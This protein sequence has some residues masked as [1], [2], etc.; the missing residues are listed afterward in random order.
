MSN[1]QNDIYYENK[2]EYEDEVLA[3][4]EGYKPK[5]NSLN[6]ALETYKLINKVVYNIDIDINVFGIK[7]RE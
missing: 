2:R 3:E 7:E 6:N 1:H 4:I 5:D